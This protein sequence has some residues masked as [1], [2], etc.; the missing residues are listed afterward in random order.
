MMDRS[1]RAAVLFGY[2]EP[3]RIEEV[4]LAGLKDTDVLVRV[5][6]ALARA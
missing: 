3:L 2:G 5:K 4:H 1:F 6:A